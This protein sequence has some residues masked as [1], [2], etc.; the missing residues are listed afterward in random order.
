MILKGLLIVDC[1]MLDEIDIHKKNTKRKNGMFLIL[2]KIPHLH[3]ACNKTSA[4][5]HL[6]MEM[7][8]EDEMMS[9]QK[10]AL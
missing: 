9:H 6:R 1:I 2:L 10:H 5:H 8:P 4:V 7:N 3:A